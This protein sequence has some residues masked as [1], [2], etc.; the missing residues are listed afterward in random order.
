MTVAFIYKVV[1][2]HT[3]NKDAKFLAVVCHN[4]AKPCLSLCLQPV[5]YDR[6]NVLC[7]IDF[8]L[9]LHFIISTQPFTLLQHYSIFTV[10]CSF[11][12]REP[13]ML[14]CK[15]KIYM[16]FTGHPELITKHFIEDSTTSTFSLHYR[17]RSILYLF[18]CTI[19]Y[20]GMII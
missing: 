7:V 19:A 9:G 5:F 15:P 6:L 1:L 16:Y 13:C 20:Q 10:H 17:K 12:T 11:K 4:V 2:T 3:Q 14:Y 8:R 18:I